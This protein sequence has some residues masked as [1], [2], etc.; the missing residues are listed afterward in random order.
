VQIDSE[1][2]QL[3]SELLHQWLPLTPGACARMQQNHWRASAV[4]AH[5]G[6]NAGHDI[7]LTGGLAPAGFATSV[8]DRLDRT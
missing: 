7:S 5:V 4:A 6:L 3:R 2:L 1:R 8:G